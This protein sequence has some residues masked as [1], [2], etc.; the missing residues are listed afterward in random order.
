MTNRWRPHPKTWAWNLL[1]S[2]DQL[3][4]SLLGGAPDE[5]ISSRSARA[6]RDGRRWGRLMCRFLG[7]FEKD[8]CEKA[9]TSELT[10]AQTS[11]GIRDLTKERGE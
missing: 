2:L 1:I 5:T 6:N 10:G 9:I 4:N 3:G 7:W 11:K 8:H